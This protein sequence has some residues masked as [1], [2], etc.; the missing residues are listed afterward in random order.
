MA[1][2]SKRAAKTKAA[3]KPS[4]SK[5]PSPPKNK[6]KKSAKRSRSAASAEPAK[7]SAPAPGACIKKRRSVG[8]EMVSTQSETQAR[9]P[10]ATIH[11]LPETAK[12]R[13]RKRFAQTIS[14]IN[15]SPQLGTGAMRRAPK[16]LR[17][18]PEQKRAARNAVG[19]SP[20]ASSPR[21]SRRSTRRKESKFADALPSGFRARPKKYDFST[22]R[23]RSTLD[24]KQVLYRFRREGWALCLAA[25]NT[26]KDESRT[27]SGVDIDC[28]FTLT[29]QGP[30]HCIGTAYEAI[31]EGSDY[32]V[33]FDEASA[34][35]AKIGSWCLVEKVA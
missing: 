27:R 4:P 1:M 8:S 25:R 16:R 33:E 35:S 3:S 2:A 11:D 17:L 28:L 18:S 20:P 32:L 29:L 10:R 14:E 12:T 15:L 34:A 23:Q 22:E 30:A 7:G 31:L 26:A 9:T 24:G 13:R 5:P 19:S 21:S 6:I